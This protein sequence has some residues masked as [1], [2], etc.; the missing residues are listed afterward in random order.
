M[1]Y[2]TT[3]SVAYPTERRAIEWL[4]GKDLEGNGSGLGYCTGIYMEELKENCE[5]PQSVYPVSGAEIWTWDFQNA[6]HK[7]KP[8]NCN[9]RLFIGVFNWPNPSSRTMALRST[10]PLTE[11]SIANLLGSKGRPAREAN[12]ITAI[13]EL[14]V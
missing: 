11:M 8:F 3:L 4:I 2:L 7:Y 9:I 12:N 10:Q 1:A 6:K 13:C 5:N 14:I